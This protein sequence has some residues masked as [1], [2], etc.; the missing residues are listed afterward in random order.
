MARPELEGIALGARASAFR[1]AARL[2]RDAIRGDV[3]LLRLANALEEKAE[4]DEAAG[5]AMLLSVGID[6]SEELKLS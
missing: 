4:S 6:V 5:E 1:V 2:V 3:D